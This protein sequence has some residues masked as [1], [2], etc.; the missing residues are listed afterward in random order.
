[1]DFVLNAL[2]DN[3]MTFTKPFAEFNVALTKYITTTVEHVIVPLDTTS[4]LEPAP[5]VTVAKPTI[6]ILSNAKLATVKV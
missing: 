3:F 5:S 1:M 4:F 2:Q 6:T